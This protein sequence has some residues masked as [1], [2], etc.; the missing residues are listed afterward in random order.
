MED[1]LK[2]LKNIAINNS[3][4]VCKETKYMEEGKFLDKIEKLSVDE[5]TQLTIKMLS[6]YQV[7][8]LKNDL[9]NNNQCENKIKI[10][11]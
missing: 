4:E 7:E 11:Q 1:I 2:T 3:V 8:K 6:V 9:I 10:M 5:I